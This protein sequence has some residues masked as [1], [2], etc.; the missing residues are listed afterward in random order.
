M[1]DLKL[2]IFN[3]FQNS[4]INFIDY[5]FSSFIILLFTGISKSKFIVIVYYIEYNWD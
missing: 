1:M 2:D 5:N 4:T 3:S